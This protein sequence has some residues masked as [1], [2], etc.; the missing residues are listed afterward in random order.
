LSRIAVL[1]GAASTVA[2]IDAV[3]DWIDGRKY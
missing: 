1:V 2:L 3:A